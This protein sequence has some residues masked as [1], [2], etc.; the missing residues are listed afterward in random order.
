MEALNEIQI[1]T[2]KFETSDKKL[3]TK[4]DRIAKLEQANNDLKEKQQT[5]FNLVQQLK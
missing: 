1:V 2:G 3:S 5:M 4:E